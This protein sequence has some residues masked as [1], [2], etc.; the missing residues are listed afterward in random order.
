MEFSHFQNYYKCRQETKDHQ[1]HLLFH[2]RQPLKTYWESWRRL[3][4]GNNRKVS[5]IGVPKF[6]S[7]HVYKLEP[8]TTM[9]VLSNPT[10]IWYLQKRNEYFSI[11]SLKFL[12]LSPTQ[13]GHSNT[14][15]H[16]N[17]SYIWKVWKR[18][19]KENSDK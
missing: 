16:D 14:S 17:T 4:V 2:R 9:F 6:V 7:L 15:A 13:N 5:T 10:W 18:L 3:I 11:C 8:D 12:S 19:D 1:H